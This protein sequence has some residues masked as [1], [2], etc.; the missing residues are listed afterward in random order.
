[1]STLSVPPVPISIPAGTWYVYLWL[2]GAATAN[3]TNPVEGPTSLF[4]DGTPGPDAYVSYEEYPLSD[5]TSVS[6]HF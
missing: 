2:G 6:P 1:M 4:I 5:T 3:W